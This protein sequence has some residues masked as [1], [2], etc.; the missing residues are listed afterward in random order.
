M[1]CVTQYLFG[2]GSL[3]RRRSR[4]KTG[5]HGGATPARVSGIKRG[6]YTVV[7]SVRVTAAGAIAEPGS[8]CNGVILL[9]A[10]AQL[11]RFDQRE[12]VYGYDRFELSSYSVSLLDGS[13][14][15]ERRI[16]T[17]LT[18]EP[19]RPSTTCPIIQSYIDV[20]LTG[21][22]DVGYRFAEEFVRSTDGWDM[23]W[24][25][26]RGDPRYPGAMSEVHKAQAIDDLLKELVPRAF[27]KRTMVSK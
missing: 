25:D 24:I 17:Y 5:A 6:W 22:L 4:P 27:E 7:P 13:T 14:L 9:V 18:R 1:I 12:L 15:P 16:W 20:V 23:P 8:S 10:D 11:P 2:Y 19:G 3:I 26:D 21:C